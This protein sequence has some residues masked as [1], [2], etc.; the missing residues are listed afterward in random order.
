VR[1]TTAVCLL[2]CCLMY[3]RKVVLPVP[4]LP[5]RK[6]ERLVY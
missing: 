6:T 5:V 3:L 4:A 1:A 2:M